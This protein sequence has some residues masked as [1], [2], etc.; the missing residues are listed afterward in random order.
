MTDA[1]QNPS[2]TPD[3][4]PQNQTDAN[5]GSIKGPQRTG[6]KP[7]G[8]DVARGSA[9]DRRRASKGAR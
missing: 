7:G 9:G 4:K 5:Q 8:D 6:D 1:R 2:A 3:K